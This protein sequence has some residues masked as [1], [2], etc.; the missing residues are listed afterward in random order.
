MAKAKRKKKASKSTSRVFIVDDHPLVRRGLSEL[1]ND[2][3]GLEVIGDAEDADTALTRI[4]RKRPDLVVVD[5]SLKSG[6]GIELIKQ[7]HEHDESILMLVSSMHD[8]S[9]Y[10]ERAVN[11]GASGYINKQEAPEKVIEAIHEILAGRVFLSQRMKD[12]LLHR[13]VETRSTRG[14]RGIELLSNR[15]LEVLE[16]VS[17]GKTTRVIAE[18]LGL[19]TK[20]IETY[21]ENIKVKLDLRNANELTRYAV[22]WAME[23][24]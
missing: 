1:I 13:M 15:E 2:E 12:R 21:R 14:R 3:A 6:H 20:T 18:H 7:I 9:L 24:S 17:L 10:A 4:K 22:Q 19:S 11:A 23:N 16:Q 5:I 8:E